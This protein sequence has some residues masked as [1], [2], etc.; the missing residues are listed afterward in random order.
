MAA[1]CVLFALSGIAHATTYYVAA[2]GSDT[3]DGRT[4][5]KPFKTLARAAKAVSPG[6]T[7]LIRGGVYLLNELA[8]TRGMKVEK[9]YPGIE[10]VKSGEPGKP[11][12]FESYQGER[13]VFEGLI[14]IAASWNVLRNITVRNSE[15]MGVDVEGTDN[16]VEGVESFG[17]K[18]VGINVG[19]Y[20]RNLILNCVSHDNY[21]PETGGEHEDGI[22][23][24]GPGTTVKG[25]VSYHNSDDGF[26][27]WNTQ[28]VTF[29]GCV[30]H[31]NGYGERGDGNGFKLG[32]N[33]KDGE[34]GNHTVIRCVAYDNMAR[35][36]DYNAATY[37]SI[38]Y[39]NTAYGN[40][41]VNFRFIGDKK[42][43]LKNNLSFKGRVEVARAADVER[44]SWDL[45]IEEP[46]FRS[47]N[48]SSPLF[49]RLSP[50]SPCIDAG[51]DVGQP[52]S[53]KAPDLGAY[54]RDN[55]DPAQR[56]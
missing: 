42:W 56:P 1:L 35:G 49:L 43:V 40:K 27:T 36:F 50:R 9:T 6:D 26:D 34:S 16:V 47:L 3:N 24:W 37:P 53:G 38:L 33:Y 2:D 41:L 28:H 22:Q 11:I 45:G 19:K 52:Y 55:S 20:P 23:I 30:A 7:V 46:N 12:I 8:S 31:S 48:P 4:V 25:C 54:E 14:V 51:V 18:R 15:W 13:A 32:G 21:N 17:N 39:N 5:E 44:N 29:I 10:L